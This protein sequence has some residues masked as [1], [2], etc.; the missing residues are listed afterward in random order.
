MKD[1]TVCLFEVHI[2][3]GLCT[4]HFN[5]LKRLGD[6]LNLFGSIQLLDAALHNHFIVVF[7]NCTLKLPGTQQLE[8]KRGPA[9]PS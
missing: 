1:R 9:L 2:D 3:S 7:E 5:V 8:C 6:D 4:V